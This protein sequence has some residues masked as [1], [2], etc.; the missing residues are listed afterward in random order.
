MAPHG[1]PSKMTTSTTLHDLLKAGDDQAPAIRAH[2]A[3]PLTY[4]G[5]R[6]LVIR[7]IA[8]LN[9]LESDA[10]TASRSCSRMAPRWRRRSLRPR[11]RRPL[12]R[13]IPAIA[14]TSS[15]STCRTS[16]PRRSSSRKAA[17]H[18]PSPSPGSAALCSS[19]SSVI[20]HTGQAPSRFRPMPAANSRRDR[21]RRG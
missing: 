8:R 4:A 21:A 10:A 7:T 5:F 14:T 11:R 18:P 13:S 16:T 6:T 12:R 3:E 17:R 1:D 2:D 20:L 15:I 19:L 9:E